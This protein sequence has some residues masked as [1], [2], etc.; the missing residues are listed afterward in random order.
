MDDIFSILVKLAGTVL[1]ALL[2]YLCT[3]VKTWLTNK[4]GEIKDERL[5]ELINSFAES[6]E[7]TLKADDPTGEKRFERVTQLLNEAGVEV[8]DIVRSMIEAAVY[9]I[10]L[11]NPLLGDNEE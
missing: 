9:N 2:V 7:Q 8:N 1:A 6:A 11:N 5:R 10:N 3:K 4:I